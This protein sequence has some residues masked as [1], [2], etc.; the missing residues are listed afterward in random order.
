MPDFPHILAKNYLEDSTITYKKSDGSDATEDEVYIK[1]H[2]IDRSR[3]SKFVGENTTPQ[4]LIFDLA[5]EKECD[6]F[7]LDKDFI[8]S[9]G[10]GR[11]LKLQHSAADDGE[12][13][14]TDAVDL[15]NAILADNSLPIW[16]TFVA[17]SRR[18]WRIRLEGLTAAPEIFNIWLGKRI[19]LTFGPYGD[20]DP[21]EEESVD[22][23]LRSESGGF[24]NVHYYS[25]RKFS[26][27]W[28][29]LTDTQM[30][31]LDQWWD[32]AGSTGLNWWFLWEPDNY[33]DNPGESNAPVY[34]NSAGMNRKFGFDR[35]VRSGVIEGMEVL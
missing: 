5:E 4:Y 21:W 29:N 26:F 34:L 8:I 10:A 19:Q 32:E 20:F 17:V 35:S 12:T 2:L 27:S 9:G 16:K 31:L 11:H 30:T 28:E 7:V 3:I 6:C 22:N 25:F 23:P 13:F 18:Y 14:D 24:Q 1:E 15:N 33:E